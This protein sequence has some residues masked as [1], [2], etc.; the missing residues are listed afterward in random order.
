M[1]LFQKLKHLDQK[2]DAILSHQESIATPNAANLR[3]TSPAPGAEWTPGEYVEVTWELQGD[4]ANPLDIALVVPTGETYGELAYLLVAEE[5]D[6]SKG[7]VTFL[8]PDVRARLALR[9]RLRQRRPADR[10]QPGD[11]HHRA[12]LRPTGLRPGGLRP[13][14]MTGSGLQPGSK[15]ATGS[16]AA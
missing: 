15:P 1:G 3:V 8:V 6:P 4:V 13:G 12:G 7:S 5:V 11:H 9:G 14:A 16:P 10:L 2:A